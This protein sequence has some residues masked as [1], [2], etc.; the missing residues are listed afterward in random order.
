MADFS[1]VLEQKY[2]LEYEIG[3]WAYGSVRVLREHGTRNLRLCHVVS[4]SGHR[5]AANVAAE[6][7]KLRS[8]RH[9][10]ISGLTDVL[11]DG[12]G[13]Y[14]IFDK[15]AGGDLGELVQRLEDDGQWLQEEVCACYIRQLLAAL[16]HS[17]ASN[18]VHG[19]LHPN[20]LS[21]TSR[22]A[23]AA[24]RV[25][26]LGLVPVLEQSG[27]VARNGQ[28]PYLAPEVR[29][30]SRSS[31][32]GPAADMWGVGA[33]ARL[34]L[35]GAPPKISSPVSSAVA[36]VAALLPG[37][38]GEGDDA[39]YETWSERSAEARDFV[40]K[41]LC[42]APENRPTAAE[43][44]L[45]P[46][47]LR[48]A[49]APPVPVAMSR[50]NSSLL[51]VYAAAH[52][53]YLC[54]LLALLL[55]PALASYPDV[56]QLRAHFA[57]VDTD[58]DGLLAANAAVELLARSAES[59]F[60]ATFAAA[61]ECVDV[62]N[63]HV[64]DQCSV[65]CAGI[66]ARE[67]LAGSFSPWAPGRE[68]ELAIRMMKRLFQ[69]IGP[70]TSVHRLQRLP[71]SAAG[72]YIEAHYGVSYN[73][74]LRAIPDGAPLDSQSLISTLL[75]GRGVGTPLA[76]S[77]QGSKDGR[78]QRVGST[79]GNMFGRFVRG[80]FISCSA[81]ETLSCRDRYESHGQCSHVFGLADACTEHS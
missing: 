51:D 32:A 62:L 41:L 73:A 76:W 31:S 44:L 12:E 5:D 53:R 78:S 17:H 37:L 65:L 46:W 40:L 25:G 68:K 81:E 30:D 77:A 39:L 8:L 64:Y 75:A 61:L 66:V 1:P 59:K 26:G 36:V 60:P 29:G 69:L 13:I 15:C 4:G 63:A 33:I 34:L 2:N 80:F 14:V 42:Q 47:L 74:M 50:D 23:D 16:A 58:T 9:E 27:E 11:H 49:F 43:A 28:D 67:F 55:A 21:L 48:D 24:I 19:S 38:R 52:H 35:I 57:H 54:Y 7:S 72:K 18:V 3:R 79:S 6:L 56:H 45:H 70:D 22:A 10:H 20:W 71:T